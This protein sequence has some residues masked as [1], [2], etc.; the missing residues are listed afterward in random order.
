MIVICPIC[1]GDLGLITG[2]IQ[3]FCCQPVKSSLGRAIPHL[4]QYLLPLFILGRGW[5]E[6]FLH[7]SIYRRQIGDVHYLAVWVR[8]AGEYII[9][10][11]IASDLG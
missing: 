1:F 8:P 2:I 5:T 10:Q 9:S 4:H 6:C 11:I 7:K 3:T